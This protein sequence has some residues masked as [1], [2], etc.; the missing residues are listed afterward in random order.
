MN[1]SHLAVRS[2][3]Q[4]FVVAILLLSFT[5]ATFFAFEPIVGRAITDDFTVSQTITSEISFLVAV[6]NV[7]M[8]GTIAGVTGGYATGTAVTSVNTNNATGYRMTLHFATSTSGRSMQASSTAYIDD[9]TPA[10]VGVP[11]F[12]WVD[13]STGQAAE[14]GY[15]VRASTTN[16]VDP[17]F[18]DNGTLCNTGT[19]ETNDRCWMS[20][21]TTSSAQETIINSP[22][23]NVSSTSTIKFK[24]AVPNNPSPLLPSGV[25]VATGTL[26][27]FTNP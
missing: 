1:K 4:A 8:N 20:P 15:T 9:Y 5:L 21:T 3:Q 19:N 27:A 24:V 26:T 17:S 23:S 14:F 2:A 16:E 25:Y 12:T 7:A 18:R 11:D 22:Y 6:N 13:N 10:T